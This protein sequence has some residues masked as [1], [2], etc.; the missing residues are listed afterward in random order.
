MPPAAKDPIEREVYLGPGTR[1][2]IRAALS[3]SINNG[4]K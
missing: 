2:E 3:A 4:S 1:D